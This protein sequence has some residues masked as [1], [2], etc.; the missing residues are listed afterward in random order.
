MGLS[1]VKIRSAVIRLLTVPTHFTMCTLC[2]MLRWCKV[3]SLTPYFCLFL[4][5][6]IQC[7]HTIHIHILTSRICISLCGHIKA[8]SRDT[9]EM[10]S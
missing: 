9:T 3:Y 8:K 1:E 5:A 4:F 7:I 10:H 2:L 6:I